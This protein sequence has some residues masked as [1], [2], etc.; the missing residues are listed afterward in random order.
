[1]S[2]DGFDESNSLEELPE[3]P[4]YIIEKKIGHGGMADVYKGIQKNLNREVAIKIINSKF[5][6]DKNFTK[7]FLFEAQTVAQLAHPNIVIIHD[8]GTYKDQY[9]IV[10]E[11]LEKKLNY[12]IKQEGKLPIQDSL[13]ILKTTA[14]ALKYAHNKGV[15]HRD[16][17]PDNCMFRADG[18]LV[19]VDFGLAKVV[20]ADSSL[21]Q[22]GMRLGT[23]SYMSPEQ[24]M[25]KKIDKRSDIYSLGVMFFKMLTGSVPY[26][27]EEIIGLLYK[28]IQEPVPKLKPE[29]S[30]YQELLD[31]MMEKDRD[32]RIQNADTLIE[33]IEVLES[34]ENNSSESNNIDINTQKYKITEKLRV[35]FLKRFKIKNIKS[36]YLLIIGIALTISV[37][38]IFIGK[39]PG[40]K[41]TKAINDIIDPIKL[42][43]EVDKKTNSESITLGF[44]TYLAIA[45][46]DLLNKQF[47]SA[48][49]N[50]EVAKKMNPTNEVISIEKEI[51]NEI[52]KEKD[53]FYKKLLLDIYILVDEKKY[54]NALKRIVEIEKIKITPDTEK[55]KSTTLQRI[56]DSKKR[57]DKKNIKYKELLGQA[58]KLKDN[59]KYKEALLKLIE[60]EKIKI[61]K[62][63]K[64]LKSTIKKLIKSKKEKDDPNKI[65]KEYRVLM[66]QV[67]KLKDEKK[68]KESL[69]KLAE[70]EKI[71]KTTETEFVKKEINKNMSF[72]NI[73]FKD[74][75]KKIQRKYKKLTKKI[76]FPDISDGIIVR[77][78]IGFTF[79][80]DQSGELIVKEMYDKW[81]NVIPPAKKNELMEK[82]V[83]NIS[84]LKFPPPIDKEGVQVIL[85]NW[86]I[87]F[88]ISSY[89]KGV[90]LRRK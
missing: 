14:E 7:R 63:T 39:N 88:K 79:E 73:L 87:T 38:F 16:I 47:D 45:K 85:E 49:K 48:L 52:E 57:S 70:V 74:L 78:Q 80:I 10:M 46:K 75:K 36:L 30:G 89:L 60:V 64:K 86:R 3:I 32:K 65:W 34:R 6:R 61:S 13:K 56:A 31:G 50:I 23:P 90:L 68:Y 21:S 27:T 11:Y 24:C 76:K 59:K 54:E 84:K 53:S 33:Q 29:F 58:K 71:I 17:K 9:F 20:D 15:I 62:D 42:K 44:G 55:L 5:V 83:E 66:L 69:A 26:N 25:G 82:L 2:N 72:K 12:I 8:T 43:D 81:V 35:D 51:R 37:Y 1:M 18:T 19:L 77:G 22:T 28:H 40:N 41:T 4:G 67:I